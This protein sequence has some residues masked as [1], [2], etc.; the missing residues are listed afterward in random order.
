M[1][2]EE[3]WIKSM[4]T[5][6]IIY[7]FSKAIKP[8]V[9]D[10]WNITKQKKIEKIRQFPSIKSPP[11][12]YGSFFFLKKWIISIHCKINA[13]TTFFKWNFIQKL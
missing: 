3:D 11:L 8:H 10:S 6:Y 5:R 1:L 4:Y 13:K 9:Y 12:W 2:D 7:G